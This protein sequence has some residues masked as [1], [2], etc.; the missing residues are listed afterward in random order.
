MNISYRACLVNLQSLEAVERG[1]SYAGPNP[2]ADKSLFLF[3]CR[4]E[5]D[6]T[7]QLRARLR[8]HHQTA[9]WQLGTDITKWILD[10]YADMSNRRLARSASAAP[11]SSPREPSSELPGENAI[12]SKP[13]PGESLSFAYVKQF[14]RLLL[15]T[16]RDLTLRLGLPFML[17]SMYYF[18]F[19]SPSIVVSSYIN[20]SCT[21]MPCVAVSI[22]YIMLLLLVSMHVR[23]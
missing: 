4:D 15:P 17:M 22:L 16:F 20:S 23:L 21:D 6:N 13:P 8:H 14:F 18:G 11:T 9:P 1:S 7:G 2:I 10:R 3:L 5:H 19:V 12:E